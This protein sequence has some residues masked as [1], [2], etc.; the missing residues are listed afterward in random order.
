MNTSNDPNDPH[1]PNDD[2]TPDDPPFKSTN[3]ID[4]LTMECMMNKRHYKTYLEKTNPSKL[5]ET[6]ILQNKIIKNSIYIET[7]FD[8][9]LEN[10]KKC[11]KG[12]NMRYNNEL[13]RAFYTFIEHSLEYIENENEFET[14]LTPEDLVQKELMKVYGEEEEGEEHEQTH[15]K[16]DGWKKYG[17]RG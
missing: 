15:T 10:S 2:T 5:K 16:N 4:K 9:L 7:I 6:Q 3:Y 14:E 13:Q 8:G 1:D 17:K 12:Q 11:I